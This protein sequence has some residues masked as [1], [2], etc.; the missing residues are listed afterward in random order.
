MQD[1]PNPSTSIREIDEHGNALPHDPADA[2]EDTRKLRVN[3]F[4]VALWVLDAAI[5]SLVSW[6]IT[7][8]FKP[9]F[10]GGTA[11]ESGTVPVF[12]V[13][14]N[15]VPQILLISSLTTV[16]L[17]FWHAWQWQKRRLN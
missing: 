16:A 15:S 6:A 3:P 9:T 2:P 13:L 14:M 8:S 10:F 12:F 1:G 11:P 17:L 4:I 5:I 7:E